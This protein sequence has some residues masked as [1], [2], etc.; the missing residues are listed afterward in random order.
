M[1]NK[2][3]ILC[4]LVVILGITGC[5]TKTEPIQQ[6]KPAVQENEEGAS[7]EIDEITIEEIDKGIRLSLKEKWKRP[8]TYFTT[9]EN[10]DVVTFLYEHFKGDLQKNELFRLDLK[11]KKLDKLLEV[12]GDLWNGAF[13]PVSE[14]FVYSIGLEELYVKDLHDE[15]RKIMDNV[16][17]YNMSPDH[18]YIVLSA[19]S[20]QY[21]YHVKT[22][23]LIET[24]LIPEMD[25]IFSNLVADW[26]IDSIHISSIPNGQGSLLNVIDA[27]EN[28]LAAGIDL[29]DA[30]ISYPKWSPDGKH[31]AFLVQS[32]EYSEYIFEQP[33]L[34]F[35]MSDKIGILNIE[36]HAT[37]YISLDEQL[38]VKS[39]Q[40]KSDSKG[41]FFETA[42]ID[43]CKKIMDSE[44]ENK[45]I[46][47]TVQYM[48]IGKD[49]KAVL[50]F[51]KKIQYTDVYSSVFPLDLINDDFIYSG[52]F[53]DKEYLMK[54]NIENEKIDVLYEEIGY[55]D[56][57]CSLENLILFST[58]SGVYHID[59]SF[60]VDLIYD[61][62]EYTDIPLISP[63]CNQ[64]MITHESEDENYLEFITLDEYK[65]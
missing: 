49:I 51:V 27:R 4:F 13:D 50:D 44:L 55:I 10:D 26:N 19:N 22:D 57:W 37:E 3:L 60:N 29:K 36:T 20:K 58:S 52:Y 11:N 64:L 15:S 54:R 34:Y 59:Q 12:E 65:H 31:L 39:L 18:Q 42:S 40:W 28:K 41:L 35:L 48:E 5:E 61:T 9:W 23:H 38:I 32:P 2:F 16:N 6:D 21:L 1:R 7:E 8:I 30:I 47:V 53:D 17:W 43:S 46:S 56:S 14:K 62:S 25:Y 63:N 45:E 24:E 33:E